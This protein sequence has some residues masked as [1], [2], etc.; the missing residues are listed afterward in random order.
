MDGLKELSVIVTIMDRQF[1]N[2]L[3]HIDFYFW[4]SLN[5]VKRNYTCFEGK[6]AF[7]D[8]E[9]LIAYYFEWIGIS[10]IHC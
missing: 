2:Y 8:S 9:P 1:Y 7:I 10:H 3:L 6:Y 4:A 5:L